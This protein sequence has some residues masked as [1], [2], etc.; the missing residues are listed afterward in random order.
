MDGKPLP[1]TEELSGTVKNPQGNYRPMAFGPIARSSTSRAKYAGTYDQNWIDNVF[2]FL[3]ADF[4]ERYY[5]SAPEDQQIDY[6]LGGEEVVLLNLTPAG[7]AEFK[8]PTIDMPVTFY[9]KNSEEK[10]TKAN[11]DTVIIE[12]E[13]NRFIFAWRSTI[14]LKKN[15][16]E[17]AQVVVGTMPRAWH[18]A[19]ELGKTWYP[20][21]KELVDERVSA[22]V[23]GEEEEF[24]EALEEAET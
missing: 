7:R 9:Y 10:E 14:P 24:A 15:M 4:D 11:L 12:P 16:F 3:P 22:R 21:L 19:R 2:P 6:P 20:S 23:E 18:R 5:Q 8:L 13:L 1:N 17:M